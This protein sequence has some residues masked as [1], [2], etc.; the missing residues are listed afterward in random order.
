MKTVHIEAFDKKSVDN[1]ILELKS[2]KKEWQRKA[3]LCSEMIAAAL[4]DEIQKNLDAINV[5][6]DM[7]DVKH[8]LQLPLRS[9]M[10][11]IAVG[12]KVVISGVE[13][14]FVEFGSGIYHNP[15]ADN[16][17]SE[18][19]SFTTQIGSYGKGQGNQTY[20]FVR[21]N[22]ISRGTPAYMPIYRAIETIAVIAPTMIRTVFV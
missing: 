7:L 11:A 3:N 10:N 18:S 14:V 13:I 6:D 15:N 20:W 22:V 5:T 19:V 12:N 21:H 4:A 9:E 8:H 1:A 16:P 17:L 2:V